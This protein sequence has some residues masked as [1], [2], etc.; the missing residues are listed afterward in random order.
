MLAGPATPS[1]LDAEAEHHSA[2]VMLC[3][4]A[5]RHPATRIGHVE[6]DVDDLARP[7]EHR[8]LPDEVRLLD[9]ISCQ[10]EKATRTVDVEGV[11]HRMVGVH[12]VDQADLD[13]VSNPEGP[14][15]RGVRR[16]RITV[17]ELPAHV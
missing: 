10:N 6:G 2:F 5:V 14:V 8:V 15:D 17:D 7:D 13:L 4:V 9:A 16:T 11:R 1:W 12:L 3:D